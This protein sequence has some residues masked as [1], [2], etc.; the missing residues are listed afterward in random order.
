MPI[1]S[2]SQKVHFREYSESF[3]LTGK[4][5]ISL[6]DRPKQDVCRLVGNIAEKPEMQMEELPGDQVRCMDGDIPDEIHEW[7]NVTLGANFRH[8]ILKFGRGRLIQLSWKSTPLTPRP[9]P[10]SPPPAKP[11]WKCW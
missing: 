8:L 7:P 2:N 10:P 5:L 1:D 6:L 4:D 3:D 11:W 9:T